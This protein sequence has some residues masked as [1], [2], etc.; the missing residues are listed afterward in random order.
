ML[1]ALSPRPASRCVTAR[2]TLGAASPAPDRS[3]APPSSP[4]SQ[5]E[6]SGEEL[7]QNH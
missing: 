7:F 1:A 2:R 4:K 6:W 5:E 3:R